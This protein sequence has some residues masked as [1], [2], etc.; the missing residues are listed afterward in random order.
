MRVLK[1]AKLFEKIAEQ[2]ERQIRSHEIVKRKELPFKHE[3]MELV[4]DG[5]TA[6]RE[7]LFDLRRTG[8][9]KLHRKV[10]EATQWKAM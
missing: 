5:R 7:A 4:G 6:A 8:L 3:F 2:L 9:V 1:R 10:R